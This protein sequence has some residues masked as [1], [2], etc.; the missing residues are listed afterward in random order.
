MTDETYEDDFGDTQFRTK[1][2]EVTVPEY[3]YQV[4]Y[5][6]QNLTRS[7]KVITVG[8]GR[9]TKNVTL[10]PGEIAT[11]TVDSAM[12][13]DLTVRIGGAVRRFPVTYEE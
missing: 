3:D 10:L 9:K 2:E 12:G 4:S 6:V 1:F 5:T 11:N 13:A 8:A 7:D